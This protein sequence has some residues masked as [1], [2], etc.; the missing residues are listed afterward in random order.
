MKFPLLRFLIGLVWFVNGL[1][2]K[3]LGM[4]PRHREIVAVALGEEIAD[5]ATLLI[6]L[7]EIALALWIWWGRFPK[8][9]ALLQIGL[10]ATMNA[11]EFFQTPDLLLW[12]RWNAV[13][14]ALF[15]VV[16]TVHGFSSH[17]KTR[18]RIPA[19]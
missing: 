13:F 9:T 18:T 14:A 1:W 4:V 6:G 5:T 11:I 2:C 7:G 19:A 12:G 17:R 8:L 3:V 10:V 15:L 16:V